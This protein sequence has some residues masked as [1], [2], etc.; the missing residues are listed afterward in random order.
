MGMLQEVSEAIVQAVAPGECQ[1]L[2]Y[3][4]HENTTKSCFPSYVENR[5]NLSFPSLNAGSA[6]IL[7]FNP[8][9]GVGDIV[10]TFQFAPGATYSGLGLAQSWG[11]RLIREIQV[12]PASGS[13]Y[14]FTGDQ[15]FLGVLSD[16]EDSVKKDQIAYLGGQSCVTSADFLD[17]SKL[18]AYVYLKLPWNSISAQEKTLPFPTDL[19]TQPVSVQVQL[20]SFDQVFFVNPNVVSP[21][22]YPTS[23]SYANANFRQTHMS[24]TGNLLTRR[25]NMV[26]KALAFPL[27]Y[28]Q[29]TTFRATQALNG[30][31]PTTAN[32]NLTG[33]RSGQL[34]SMDI[35]CVRQSDLNSGN[36]YNWVAPTDVRLLISGTVYYDSVKGSQQMWSLVDRK[37]PAAFATTVCAPDSTTNTLTDA[38]QVNAPWLNIP[39][40]QGSEVLRG[41]NEIV[42]GLN[43]ANSVMNLVLTL[44]GISGAPANDQWVISVSYNFLSAMIFNAGGVDYVF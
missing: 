30:T 14:T 28:F 31:S 8:A 15:L 29:Q 39:L 37:T 3:P 23:L 41:E 4:G 19:L 42:G 20:N 38:L 43:V 35:W 44:P 25:V 2:Y 5:F 13:Q 7:I 12:R 16:A 9:E 17:Q 1:D 26:Q 36:G 34:K 6:S 24:N 22:P 27:R 40:G 18:T 10:L 11:Y 33:L 21:S 32:L